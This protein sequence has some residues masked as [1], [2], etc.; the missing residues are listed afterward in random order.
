MTT[1]SVIVPARDVEPYIADTLAS[2]G[3]NARKDF[4]F[5]VVDDGSTDA[6]PE[7]VTDFAERLGGLSMI[8]ND[9]AVGL[10]AARNQGLAAASGR[11]IVYLDGDD[12][13]PSGYLAEALEAIRRLDVGFVKTDHVRVTGKNRV[14]V[15]APEGRRNVPLAPRS[16]I[17]PE[18]V[19]TMVDYPNAWSGI[20]DRE[21]LQ[22]RG[23]LTFNEK[24][25][26]AEDR[27]WTWRLHLHAESF[28]VVS[29]IGVCYRRS[30]A[31]S[32][33]R[34][35]DERQLHFF[36]SFDGVLAELERD[37][38][39]DR[40]LPK[41]LR[42]YCAMIAFHLQEEERLTPPL[43]RRQRQ[44]AAETLRRMPPDVLDRILGSIDNEREEQL[45]AVVDPGKALAR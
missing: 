25:L 21:K 4:E 38:E 1:L 30:V 44:R 27:E 14:L 8:R 45:R 33:T 3:R 29:L 13:L 39:G 35:G 5:I 41:A 17:L 28:A 31:G 37:P 2:L 12:W 34:I 26:T 18:N 22:D 42:S 15:R 6:T 9:A 43:R 36:D 23:L 24:L 11:Y 20:A 32:L 19:A 7:I 40:F 16:A 10:S